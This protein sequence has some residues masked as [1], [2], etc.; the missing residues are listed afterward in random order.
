MSV[1][2][3]ES[4]AAGRKP[5]QRRK[6]TTEP[7]LDDKLIAAIRA[8]LEDNERVRRTLPAGGRVNVDRQL[9]FLFV[10]R[11]PVEH[12]DAGTRDFVRGE[13]SYLIAPQD[14][15]YAVRTRSL[16]KDVVATLSKVFG[17]CLVVEVWAAP[18]QA[19]KS[20]E[21]GT[22]QPPGF[23]VVVPRRFAEAPTVLQ[24]KESLE[25]IVLF[26]QAAEVS[27]S[28]GGRI[29]ANG[30]VTLASARELDELGAD[31][32]GLEI[33]PI[34]RSAETGEEYPIAKRHLAS[35]VSMALRRA[36]FEYARTETSARPRH[37]QA[38][39]TRAFTKAAW[40]VDAA[41]ADISSEFDLLLYVS[42]TNANAAFAEFKR[43]GFER[44]PTFLYRPRDFDPGALKRRLHNINVERVEDPTMAHLFREKQGDLDL[45]LSMLLEREHERFMPL[46]VAL[47]GR[48]EAPLVALAE[49]LLERLPEHASR[50]SRAVSSKIFVQRAR[51]EFNNY[52]SAFP[53]F[54]SH[55]E[56]R[57]DITSLM[58]SQG[59]MLVGSKMTIPRNRIEPLIQHEVGTHIV[60]HWNGSAQPFKLLSAGLAHYDELQEGLAV[61]AE[62]LA[63]GLTAARMRTI[64]GRV[65]AAK[66]VVEG[67]EFVDTWRLLTHD[68]E[69]GDRAAY[70]IAMRVHRGGGFVKDSVYLR[71]VQK[72]LDYLADGG[73]LETLLV[74][75]IATDHAPIIEELQR[76]RVL[77]PSP[78]RP[79]YLDDPDGQ[80]RLDAARYGMDIL[81]LVET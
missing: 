11:P 33:R 54:T 42:P 15:R 5:A 2:A 71:G 29:G 12:A 20:D 64:A 73:H 75:K 45:K 51:E 67:A 60:T 50:P 40:E 49:S 1:T 30:M 63:A 37:Y 59:N 47:Y 17:G 10:Y 8:R 7:K 19:A 3:S 81:D 44:A 66:S 76:R 27:V 13:A 41:L 80:V 24:L 78:L 31:V 58:V 39:G 28:V 35:Q 79:A 72:V 69:F 74:G 36:V 25:K 6:K 38:L 62:Y 32:L 4:R 23:R 46:S 55:V 21:D 43:S 70:Q 18:D 26:K 68:H 16:A 57:D 52:K 14:R 65:L 34:Y 53:P 56:V 22:P 48:I 77:K 9:P 61:F